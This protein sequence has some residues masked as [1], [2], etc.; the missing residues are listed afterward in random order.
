MNFNVNDEVVVKNLQQL[1][2]EKL[3]TRVDGFDDVYVNDDKSFTLFSS[4]SFFDKKTKIN[5][6]D[7]KDPAIPYFLAC[8]CWVPEFMLTAVKKEEPKPEPV[9]EVAPVVEEAKPD[10]FINKFTGKPFGKLFV[11]LIKL[12]AKIAEFS[13][14]SFS[15]LKRHELDYIANLLNNQEGV[16]LVDNVKM[17]KDDLASWCYATTLELNV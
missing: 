13:C 3:V 1:L 10:A 15:R 5:T 12:D 7:D 16:E 9:V 4:F 14:S 2:D 6:V 8:G 11:K 17:N